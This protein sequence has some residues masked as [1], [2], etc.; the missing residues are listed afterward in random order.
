MSERGRL[1]LALVQPGSRMEVYQRL[2][3][4]L[5]AIEPPVWAGLLATFARARGYAVEIVDA[6][7]EDLAPAEVAERLATL[8]PRLAAVVVF[9]HQPSA[10]T[11]TMPAAGAI[12]AAVARRAPGLPTLLVGGHVSALP[13]RT[14]REEACDF[15]CQG[16]GPHTIVGLLEAQRAGGT[17]YDR[18]PGLWYREGEALRSTP[19]APLLD[20]L[21]RDLPQMA[22][23]LLPVPRYRAHNWHCFGFLDRRQPYASIYTSLGCPYKCT[24]CCINSPF[25]KPGYRYRS[26]DSVI[27]EI[28]L[29]V[30]KHG[31]RNIK[32]LD[33]M[34][35]LNYRHVES[36]CDRIIERGHDLNI[37]AYARVDTVKE[38]ILDRLKRAG[39]NWLALGIESGSQHVRDGAQKT[40]GR[41]DIAATVR[42]IQAAGINVIGNY[43]F[44]LPDDDHDTMQAT[45]D[46]ACEL[47]CEFANFYSAMAYPG[48]RLYD[49]A[50]AEGWPLPAAW[51]GYSQHAVDTLPLPTRFL[52]AAEVLRFRDRAFEIYFHRPEYLQMVGRKF[53]PETAAHVREMASHRLER[54]HA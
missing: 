26:A 14:L 51:S 18:V 28:D 42:A 48:S 52:S 11:Q 4:T 30:Q 31:V 36:V 6:E 13:E 20:D 32:I 16:E 24:F 21:D 33:E 8:A 40:F 7:A 3:S 44:G 49:M 2:G 54:K 38:P 10:S 25:G 23:D 1:D 37:W 9:G 39:I 27:E 45:L 15:V 41:A 29:L 46:L 22:W 53:G 34:F 35:V 12:C 17:G 47:Q 43:I 50:L 19:P 5:T